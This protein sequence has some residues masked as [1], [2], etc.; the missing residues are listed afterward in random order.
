MPWPQVYTENADGEKTINYGLSVFN[1]QLVK[2]SDAH[3]RWDAASDA[4][5][6]LVMAKYGEH[7]HVTAS[8]IR[9]AAST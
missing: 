3:R 2:P 4:M 8:T 6:G 1:G 9:R 7:P 5:E